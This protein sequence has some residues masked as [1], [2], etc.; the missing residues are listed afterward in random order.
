MIES[1]LNKASFSASSFWVSVE[2]PK[3]VKLTGEGPPQEPLLNL[4]I[5]TLAGALALC[6]IN[7][8]PP[9]K[10]R[11]SIT[12]RLAPP[13]ALILAIAFCISALS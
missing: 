12:A 11:T 1:N 13:F 4:N 7:E 9:L 10:K 5:S 8:Y 2:A 3:M 6:R